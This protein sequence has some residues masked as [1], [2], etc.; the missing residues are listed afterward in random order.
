MIEDYSQGDSNESTPARITE[1]CISAS[2]GTVLGP[3]LNTVHQ[4]DAQTLAAQQIQAHALNELTLAEEIRQ[5]TRD[6]A[7]NVAQ[8]AK[9]AVATAELYAEQ[10]QYEA[11]QQHVQMAATLDNE[12]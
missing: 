6:D 10:V 12:L 4:A 3:S 7:M 11:A 5:R 9:M 8:T 2:S 1:V